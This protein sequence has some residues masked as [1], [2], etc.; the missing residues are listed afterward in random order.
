MD[1]EDVK[2]S[3]INYNWC[4]ESWRL[5]CKH[6]LSNTN[7]F[8]KLMVAEARSSPWPHGCAA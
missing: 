7:H 2:L 8:C 1:S 6:I 3:I 5:R 4:Y